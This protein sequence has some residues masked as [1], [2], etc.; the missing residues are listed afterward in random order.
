MLCNLDALVNIEKSK[1]ITS[2][3]TY[4]KFVLFVI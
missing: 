3:Y 4:N 2:K 1:I